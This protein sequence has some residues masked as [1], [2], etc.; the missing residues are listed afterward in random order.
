MYKRSCFDSEA[1]EEGLQF[2]RGFF[3]LGADTRTPV[4]ARGTDDRDATYSFEVLEEPLHAVRVLDRLLGAPMEEA[5]E[6]I[7]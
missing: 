3:E 6:E 7:P 2:R 5:S 1:G 4:T